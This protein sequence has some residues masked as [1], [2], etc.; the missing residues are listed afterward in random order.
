MI[1]DRS[2]TELDGHFNQIYSDLAR[3]SISPEYLLRALLLQVFYSVRPER[4][5]V[6]QLNF[7]LLSRWFVGL[8]MD[9]PIWVPTV[10]TNNY[11]RLLDNGTVQ[12]FFRTVLAQAT[13]WGLL[14]GE[15]FSLEGTLLEAWAAQKFFQ[16]KDLGDRQGDGSDF[17]GQKRSNAADASVTCP[18]CRLYKKAPGDASWLAYL[19]HVLMDQRQGLI[20]G[21]QI[22]A[23]D[24]TS[25][26]DAALQ[27]L[28]ELGGNQLVTLG[29]DNGE[30]HRGFVHD[31][32]YRH[33]S[34]HVARKCME[35][36]GDGRATRHVEY[37]IS[38]RVCK[39][40]GSIFDWMKTVGVIRKRRFLGLDL[41]GLHFTPL[42]TVCN[43]VRIARL[44]MIW[45]GSCVKNS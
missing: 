27:F 28:D 21:E 34:Q 4:H 22:M 2:L 38:V 10:F 23:A 1:A 18:D 19:W 32:R 29:A 11:D 41:V 42:S 44:E 24:V 8:G 45:R 39:R 15:H 40:I 14:F 43:L 17:R 5:I 35:S 33:I 6:E 31:L 9:G 16:P 26:V 20:V 3:P 30:D 12:R 13:H 25:E 37:G 7:N 36:A